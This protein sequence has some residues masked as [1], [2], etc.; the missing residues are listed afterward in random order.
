[1]PRKK[2]NRFEDMSIVQL[3]KEYAEHLKAIEEIQSLLKDLNLVTYSTPNAII[4]TSNTSY[5]PSSN[6]V[7]S[8][9]VNNVAQ[10]NYQGAKDTLKEVSLGEAGVIAKPIDPL[11]EPFDV[12][13]LKPFQSLN[14]Q[15]DYLPEITESDSSRNFE[16]YSPEESGEEVL[17]PQEAAER[18]VKNLTE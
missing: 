3:K 18:Q 13:N 4:P 11:E 6:Y 5:N 16:Y 10:N 14:N 15:N 17:S 8:Y 12:N 9:K 1:M 2:T 7:E